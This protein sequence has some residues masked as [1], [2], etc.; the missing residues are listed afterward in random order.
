MLLFLLSPLESSSARCRSDANTRLRHR[1]PT[2]QPKFT[3]RDLPTRSLIP[4]D[5]ELGMTC[6]RLLVSLTVLVTGC[7]DAGF[8]S[9]GAQTPAN[10]TQPTAS[11]PEHHERHRSHPASHDARKPEE[12][13]SGH[14]SRG[15]PSNGKGSSGP[16]GSGSSSSSTSATPSTAPSFHPA[17]SPNPLPPPPAPPVEK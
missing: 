12:G 3:K 6:C 8:H 4:C 2:A 7:D 1:P 15:E 11:P 9:R 17:P 5:T 13:G 10:A 14:R 16:S